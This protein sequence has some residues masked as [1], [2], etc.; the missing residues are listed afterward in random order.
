MY[1]TFSIQQKSSML[2]FG[3]V[4][5]KLQFSFSFIIDEF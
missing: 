4:H 1:E 3:N 5:S 2:V